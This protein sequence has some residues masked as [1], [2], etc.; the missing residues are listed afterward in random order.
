MSRTFDDIMHTFLMRR[1]GHSLLVALL[2]T[3]CSRPPTPV[4]PLVPTVGKRVEGARGVVSASHPDAARAGGEILAAGGNAADAAAAVAFALAVVDPSQTGLGGGGVATIYSAA[5]R[6]ADVLQFYA[7][8][9]SDPRWG[10]RDS[11]PPVAGQS[12]RDAGVPGAVRGILQLQAQWGRLDRA[13]V[14]APAIRLARDGFIVSPL[15][16]RTIASARSK[17][18]ADSVAGARYLPGGEPLQAGDRLVQP[19]LGTLLEQIAGN[20]GDAFYGGGFASRLSAEVQRRGGY[21]TVGDMARYRTRVERPVCGSFGDFQVL[22]AGPSMGGMTV[23]EGLMAL[24]ATRATG[25]DGD[26]ARSVPAARAMTSA[27]RLAQYDTRGYGGDPDVV[28]LASP[29]RGFSN[30]AFVA[31]RV[32]RPIVD[33][34]AASAAWRADGEAPSAG[35]RALDPYPSAPVTAAPGTAPRDEESAPVSQT[36]HLSVVDAEGNAVG[37]TYTVGTLFG[38]GVYVDGVFLNSGGS[39]FNARTRGPDRF[40]NSTIA[41]TVIVDQRGVRLV[42]G[43]GGSQYIPTSVTQVAWRILAL[44]ADPWLAIASPRLQPSGTSRDIEMEPGFA[45][46][47]YAAMR[48]DGYKVISRVGDLMFGGVHLV[49]VAPNGVRIGAADPRRDGMAVVQ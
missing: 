11:T 40:A 39:N 47:I 17:L 36:S 2:V 6:R 4:S 25:G 27:L 32:Q 15:L 7:R 28:G 38:S 13:R 24:D 44:G 10:A 20:G 41:P 33:S 12:G 45:P 49:Y 31:A 5:T 37:L 1:L 14:M 8:S 22:G 42:V 35:C 16:S 43:A 3:G 26:H 18:M 23:V 46:E 9:G 48:A 34:T 30:A 21:I 19:E 29:M